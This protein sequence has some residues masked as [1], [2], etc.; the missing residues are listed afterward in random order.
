MRKFREW[1]N[2]REAGEVPNTPQ[3][4]SGGDTPMPLAHAHGQPNP[5]SGGAG[6][7]GGPTQGGGEDES[8]LTGNLE[9]H[10]NMLMTDLGKLNRLNKG[11]AGEILNHIMQAMSGLG[12]QKNVA[13]SAVRQNF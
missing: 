3:M 11:K 10:F 6:A 12:V 1:V 9:R 8:V 4:S 2:V 13:T 5:T 7:G